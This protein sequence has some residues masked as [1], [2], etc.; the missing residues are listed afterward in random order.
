MI[1]SF[2]QGHLLSIYVALGIF[3]VLVRSTFTPPSIIN[4]PTSFHNQYTLALSDL[5]VLGET[6]NS[7]YPLC[8]SIDID[9]YAIRMD[10]LQWSNINITESVD[11]I[12]RDCAGTQYMH[13]IYIVCFVI[14]WY[15]TYWVMCVVIYGYVSVYASKVVKSL[16]IMSSIREKGT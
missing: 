5:W 8:K 11:Y 2:Y 13:I 12:C 9:H 1:L 14:A 4:T 16:D 10:H 7:H 6:V 15:L 3:I